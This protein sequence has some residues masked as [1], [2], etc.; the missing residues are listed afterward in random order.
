MTRSAATTMMTTTGMI[1]TVVNATGANKS[2][3]KPVVAGG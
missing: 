1:V 3:W 2:D